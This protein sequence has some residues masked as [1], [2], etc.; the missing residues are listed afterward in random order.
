[1]ELQQ[2]NESTFLT[3]WLMNKEHMFFFIWKEDDGIRC[4][5]GDTQLGFAWMGN[6]FTHT[7]VFITSFLKR[8]DSLAQH[9]IPLKV[10][11]LIFTV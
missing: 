8:S 3:E 9:H 2:R 11:R 5:T 1:M 7:S 4:K 6:S 10:G